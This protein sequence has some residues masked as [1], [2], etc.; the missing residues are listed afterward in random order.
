VLTLEGPGAPAASAA[1]S[2]A[3]W[4]RF[5]RFTLPERFADPG[6]DGAWET[7]LEVHLDPAKDCGCARLRV[8][9]GEAVS[10]WTVHLG[11]SPTNNGHGGDEGTTSDAAEMHVL[12]RQVT[13]YTVAQA[14]R[15]QVDRLLDVTVPPLGG[16]TVEIEACDQ[17]LGFEILPAAGEQASPSK[18]K[19]ETLSAGLLFSLVPR[20]EREGQESGKVLYVAFNRV[21]HLVTGPASRTRVGSGVRRVGISLTP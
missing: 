18:W 2:S 8:S 10:G 21:I 11:D 5:L 9:F 19:L 4:S 16:R 13:V 6:R 17:S 3:A 7:V 1:C 14:A 12:E 20:E 15:R